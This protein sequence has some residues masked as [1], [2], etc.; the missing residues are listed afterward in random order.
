MTPKSNGLAPSKETVEALMA[1]MSGVLSEEF[2]ALRTRD[3]ERLEATAAHK[4]TIVAALESAAHSIR[5]SRDAQEGADIADDWPELQALARDCQ[6]A[7]RANGGAIALNRRLVS[8]LLD[9]LY[10]VSREQRTYDAGGHLDQVE[11]VRSVGQ[12]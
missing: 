10:G 2:D 3:V 11:A 5:R 1:E 9:T 8:N 6:M 7:N 4:S 12:A